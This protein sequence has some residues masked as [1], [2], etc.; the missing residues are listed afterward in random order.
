MQNYLLSTCEILIVVVMPSQK[1]PTYKGEKVVT[2]QTEPHSFGAAPMNNTG[3]SLAFYRR[4]ITPNTQSACFTDCA[5]MRKAWPA[6]AS[7]VFNVLFFSTFPPEIS[8]FGASPSHE[9]KCFSLGNLLISVP[10]SMITVCA[11]E[12]PNPSTTLRSTPLILFKCLRIPSGL[13]GLFLLCELRFR[14]S[15][16][17]TSPA[18]QSGRVS[19]YSRSISSSHAWI[20]RV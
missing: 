15:N 6:L 16:C 18:S 4:Y 3:P 20:S 5:A 2:R 9:Q 8:C 12:T 17:L 19:L 13:C 14:G 11:S 10:T 7:F 1:P